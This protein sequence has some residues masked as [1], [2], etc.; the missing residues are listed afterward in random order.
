MKYSLRIACILFSVA[1]YG[2]SD[3]MRTTNKFEFYAQ[4][5][6]YYKTFF[7]KRYIKPTPHNYNNH[8]PFETHQYDGFNKISTAGFNLGFLCSFNF[9]AHVGMI[10]GLVYFLRREE[11]ER[12]Q[13]STAKNY[14]IGY[15]S[16]NNVS[17]FNYS[18]HDIELPVMFKYSLKK[19]HFSFGTY[20]PL[21]TYK[22]AQ[23]T[24]LVADVNN[25]PSVS[26][27]YTSTKTVS[28]FD[29]PIKARPNGDEWQLFK[30][31]RAY[32]RYDVLLKIYP[33][34]QASYDFKIKNF[35]FSPYLALSYA[36][37]NQ[38]DFYIQ[39]GVFV[40]LSKKLFKK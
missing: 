16:I 39:A 32:S 18:Y 31:G 17:K 25:N 40:P 28:G 37:K 2:Q 20:I 7:D 34:I 1:C 23:Y 29:M 5:G 8:K 9:N 35:Q 19:I 15:R 33:T 12:N 6:A 11:F 26:T 14:S 10:T 27:W 22:I 13:D 38:N 36:L 21:I 3:T 24:Y 4:A 30:R